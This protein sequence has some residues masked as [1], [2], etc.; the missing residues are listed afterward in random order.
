VVVGVHTCGVG[1]IS[2]GRITRPVQ[3]NMF[4][5]RREVGD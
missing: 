3:D 2:A 1:A 4:A 5:R